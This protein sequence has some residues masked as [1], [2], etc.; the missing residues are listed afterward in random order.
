MSFRDEGFVV[1]RGLLAPREVEGYIRRLE[2]LSGR[3]RESFRARRGL[4][5]PL[6]PRGTRGWT[7]PDGVSK[8]RDFWPLIT[9]PGLLA[10]TRDILGADVRYLQHSDLHV[11]FSAVTWHRDA[12]NRQFGRGPDWDES[13][14]PYRLVRVGLY[15]QSF[16]ESRFALRLVP[17]SHR[18]ASPAAPADLADI[19]RHTAAWAQ[20]VALV[21]GHD[22]VARHAVTLETQ[23]GDAVLFD[24]RVL[25]AGTAI[26]G[27]KYSAFLAFGAPGRH[28]MRHVSYYRHVRRELGY[29]NLEPELVALLRAHKL[30]AEPPV[31]DTVLGAYRPSSLQ[32]LLGRGI[33]P[34][35]SY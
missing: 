5:R 35:V 17:G 29:G 14:E 11:G 31:E 28:F 3:T 34:K 12:V 33:R 6:V 8:V 15:L 7:L 10:A 22:P 20:A 4:K 32:R 16:E 21:S 23:P 30:D 19:E 1:L 27:P 26:E 25:H 24:P 18:L 2:A 9:H 13:I